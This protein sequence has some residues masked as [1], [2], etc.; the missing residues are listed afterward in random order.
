MN[1][2]KNLKR[3]STGVYKNTATGNFFAEKRVKGKLYNKT[4]NNLYDAKKWRKNFSLLDMIKTSQESEKKFSTLKNVWSSMQKNHFPTLATSTKAIWQRRYVYLKDLEHLAMDKIT[5][6]KITIWVNKW[7]QYFKSKEYK[8]SGRGNAG[9]CNMN[10]E[11]NMFVTIFNWYKESEEFEQEALH[12]TCPVKRKHRKLGFIKPVPDKKKQIDLNHAFTFFENLKPLYKDLAM[13][14]FFCAGRIGEIAGIQW[15]N[16]DLENRRMVIRHTCI[17]CMSHKTFIELKPFPKNR[18]A[19]PVYITDE[20]LEILKRRKAFKLDDNDFVFHVD[21]K[22]LNYCTI[23]INYRAAQRKGNIPYSGTHILRH[24][25][26]K[27]ARQVGGGLDAVIAMT[28]HKDLKLADH[29]SK[30]DESDQK[31][32]SQKIMRHIRLEMNT[33]SYERE[34]DDT[35]NIISLSAFKNAMNK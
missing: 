1:F 35:S 12:L 23:Q 11:L 9:R 2:R 32:F 15:S 19:R 33:D 21:G 10:N 7:T 13:M 6:S 22:P 18:E 30:C 25:M 20:I 28:G 4:F 27:L 31:E 17:W 26:A 3:V 29:Y 14:Q 34:N 5:P 16:I 8:N 24:G